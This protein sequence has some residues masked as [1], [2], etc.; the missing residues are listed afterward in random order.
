VSQL[1]QFIQINATLLTLDIDWPPSIQRLVH[2]FKA[3]LLL[4]FDVIPVSDR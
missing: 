2:T 3:V 4:T 1:V